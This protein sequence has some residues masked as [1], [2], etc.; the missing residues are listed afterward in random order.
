MS[1]ALALLAD[2]VAIKD[3]ERAA[4]KFGMPMGPIELYDMVG[5]DTALF[6]GLTMVEAFPERLTTSPILDALVMLL[7]AQR[8]FGVRK[9]HQLPAILAESRQRQVNVTNELADQVFD[10]LQILL[11]GFEGAAERD[12]HY[13]SILREAYERPDDH[14]YGGPP[15]Y[16]IKVPAAAT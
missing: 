2:G 8:F 9:E 16:W 13:A 1:E 11:R 12:N 3:I 15:S 10:A 7:S 6:A 5:L 4:K 14:L